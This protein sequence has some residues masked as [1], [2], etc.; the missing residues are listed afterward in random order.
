MQSGT[1]DVL[2]VGVMVPLARRGL[3]E[4]SRSMGQ[5]APF[6]GNGVG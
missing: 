5:G 2:G 6:P 3:P 4:L 1:L